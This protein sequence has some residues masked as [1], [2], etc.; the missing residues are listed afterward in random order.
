MIELN[1]MG[2]ERNILSVLVD[3]FRLL[4]LFQL[5]Q[6]GIDDAQHMRR[7]VHGL[8]MPEDGEGEHRHHQH[9]GQIHPPAQNKPRRNQDNEHGRQLERQ[10]MKA[11]ERNEFPFQCGY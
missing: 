2:I 8:Q 5:V 10:Q 9:D 7:V 11:I 4:D 6:R 3:K 1:V